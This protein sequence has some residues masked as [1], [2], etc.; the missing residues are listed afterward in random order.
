MLENID[1]YIGGV[2]FS[3]MRA[4]SQIWGHKN[5]KCFVC[6]RSLFFP[7]WQF[8]REP[9]FSNMLNLL[10]FLN[11]FVEHMFFVY[12]RRYFLLSGRVSG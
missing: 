9:L 3:D 12:T 10:C 8:V 2:H 1:Y 11:V 7:A 5:N 4:V 6:T